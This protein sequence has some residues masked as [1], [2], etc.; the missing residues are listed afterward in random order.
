MTTE[1]LRD[2]CRGFFK[3]IHFLNLIPIIFSLLCLWLNWKK[4][5]GSIT[6]SSVIYRKAFSFFHLGKR[7]I[8]DRKNVKITFECSFLFFLKNVP[9]TC[10]TCGILSSFLLKNKDH[11]GGCCFIHWPAACQEKEI[12]C[13]SA[14]GQSLLSSLRRRRSRTVTSVSS[15]LTWHTRHQEA[16]VSN[17]SVYFQTLNW[18][19]TWRDLLSQLE[20]IKRRSL[21]HGWWSSLWCDQS[22]KDS[23]SSGG[24]GNGSE[25]R[26]GVRADRENTESVTLEI[27]VNI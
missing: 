16:D 27:T 22:V 13:P 19:V 18:A 24:A 2:K 7:E 20:H 4:H 5:T 23:P 3:V 9:F 21:H 12:S 6:G 10:E 26:G 11:S 8:Q 17:M 25:I 1:A 14:D 15:W